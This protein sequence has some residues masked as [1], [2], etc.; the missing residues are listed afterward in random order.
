MSAQV[1]EVVMAADREQLIR[2]RAYAIWEQ[3]GY[4]DDRSLDHWLRAQAEI[5][6]DPPDEVPDDGKPAASSKG[7]RKA[8]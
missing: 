5:A 3:D 8:T 2:Q 1:E 6:I 4:P 7:R